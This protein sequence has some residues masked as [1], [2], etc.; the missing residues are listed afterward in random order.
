MVMVCQ[1]TRLANGDRGAALALW[2]GGSRGR[3][4]LMVMVEYFP[5]SPACALGDFACA[6]AGADADVFAGDGSALADIA[7]GFAWVKCG[8]VARTFP[9]TLAR[10]SSA[11]GG[12]F[13]DV[14]SAVTDVATGAGWMRLR[15]A[16]GLRRGLGLVVLTRGVLAADGKCEREERAERDGWFWKCGSH[17]S[18]LPPI[19]FDTLA[20]D[21][22]SKTEKIGR[23]PRRAGNMV[24]KWQ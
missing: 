20:E 15:C 5:N 1:S 10:R 11:L 21:S 2:F 24:Y 22:L 13:A 6:L 3:L 4:P 17:G 9:N 12:S 16:S 7:G 18:N 14:S 23:Y 8:K 19:R